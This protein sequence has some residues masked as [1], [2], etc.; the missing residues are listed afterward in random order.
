MFVP[1]LRAHKPQLNDEHYGTSTTTT[2][3]ATPTAA[4]AQHSNIHSLPQPGLQNLTN[5]GTKITS[6]SL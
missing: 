1:Y 3:A 4:A 5:F 2:A 6:I